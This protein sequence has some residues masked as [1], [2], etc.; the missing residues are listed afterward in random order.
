[1]DLIEKFRINDIQHNT[2][3]N[4]IKHNNN[5]HSGITHNNTQHNGIKHNNTQHNGTKHNDTRH[6]HMVSLSCDTHFCTFKLSV[7]MLN[8]LAPCRGLCGGFLK[9]VV[10]TLSK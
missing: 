6:K 10:F 2:Q 4:G 1:M 7:V 5:Q 8:V 3:H 9:I